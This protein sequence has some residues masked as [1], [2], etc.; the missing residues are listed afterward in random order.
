MVRVTYGSKFG[1]ETWS[2]EVSRY[3]NTEDME[4][5]YYLQICDKVESYLRQGATKVTIKVERI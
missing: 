3:I 5:D 4:P 2:Y 1:G